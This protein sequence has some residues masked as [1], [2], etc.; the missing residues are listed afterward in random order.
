MIGTKR[1]KAIDDEDLIQNKNLMW[2]IKSL[3][4]RTSEPK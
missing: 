3:N 2:E 1:N 4:M